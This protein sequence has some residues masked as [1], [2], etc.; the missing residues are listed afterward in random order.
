M[1]SIVTDR[2]CR[3]VCRSVDLSVTLVGPAK[4]AEPIDLS[5]VW[6]VDLG[7]PKEAQVQSYSPGGANMPTLEVTL[8]PPG[9][10]D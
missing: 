10:Y 6:V 8:A 4:T 1:Q 5:F 3:S 9:E 2:V 7:G